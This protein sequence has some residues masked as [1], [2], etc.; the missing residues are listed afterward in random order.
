MRCLSSLILFAVVTLAAPVGARACNPA[1][2]LC[3]PATYA[4]PA[5]PVYAAPVQL[6]PVYAAPV[7]AAPVIQKQIVVRQQA[8]YAAPAF[9]VQKQAV[10]A[11]PALAVPAYGVGAGRSSFRQ[12]TFIRQESGFGPAGGGRGLLRALRDRR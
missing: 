5:A 6:A 9:A 12:R 2:G 3:A 1:L 8:V 10:Y 4:V 7:Y 11:A